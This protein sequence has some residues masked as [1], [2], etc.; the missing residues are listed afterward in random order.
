MRVISSCR[1]R[2]SIRIVCPMT[3]SL[4]LLSAAGM[5]LLTAAV[6]SSAQRVDLSTV[7]KWPTANRSVAAIHSGD[8]TIARFN[9]RPGAGVAISPVSGFQNGDIDVDTRGRDVLQKSFVGV[10]FHFANDSTFETVWLR[11]FNY[12]SDDSTRRP[13]AV[14]YASYPAYPWQRLRSEHAGQFESA[15]VPPPK[16]DDWVHLHV[17]VRGAHVRAFVNGNKVLDVESPAPLKSGRVGLWVGDASNGDFANLV[18]RK[19]Q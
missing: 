7:S 15:V 9:E 2:A 17:E 16:A 1:R 10:V 3:L 8:T 19:L 12:R 11:P 5:L 6:G 18:I 4:N 13:H 14:Q